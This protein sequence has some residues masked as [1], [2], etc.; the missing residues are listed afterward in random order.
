M[1]M[2]YIKL[3]AFEMEGRLRVS[4]K[5]DVITVGE[6][7]LDL[8]VIPEGYR[9]PSSG[10]PS[11]WIVPGTFV[12]RVNCDLHIMLRLPAN[13]ASSESVR[14]P[15][16]VVARTDGEVAIPFDEPETVVTPKELEEMTK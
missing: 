5:G 4:T 10:I 13:P 8:S 2:I 11:N 12:E 14:N 9:L 7:V 1:E 15:L 6:D 16:P 3:F